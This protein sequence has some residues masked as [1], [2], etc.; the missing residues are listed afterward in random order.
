[1]FF[2]R[3]FVSAI[4]QKAHLQKPN[5]PKIN[6]LFPKYP[7]S[8]EPQITSFVHLLHLSVHIL[9]IRQSWPLIERLSFRK[10]IIKYIK[11]MSLLIFLVVSCVSLTCKWRWNAPTCIPVGWWR[12]AW[13]G[14]DLDETS[15]PQVPAPAHM[16]YATEYWPPDKKIEK[17]KLICSVFYFVHC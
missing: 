2:E 17:G 3:V 16:V 11:I 5:T 9:S 7:S 12:S 6:L 8:S 1:M 15:C 10:S 4:N 14:P 13:I